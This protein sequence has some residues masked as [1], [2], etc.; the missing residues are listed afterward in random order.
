MKI[1][2]GGVSSGGLLLLSL[3]APRL[4]SMPTASWNYNSTLFSHNIINANIL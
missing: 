2:A 1:F 3:L 4:L